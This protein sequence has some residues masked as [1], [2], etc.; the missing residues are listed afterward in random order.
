[1]KIS[2][3]DASDII[4]SYIIEKLIPQ[5]SIIGKGKLGFLLPVIPTW[6]MAQM[7]IGVSLGLIDGNANVDVMTFEK[8]AKSSVSV[9]EKI[10]MSG[11]TFGKEDV[12]GF[13]TFAYDKM[14][15]MNLSGESIQQK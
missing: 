8:C 1:M 6:L 4:T 10:T 3:Q 9:A 15:Q 13:F 14:K 2:I 11:F 12:E 7:P 5:A